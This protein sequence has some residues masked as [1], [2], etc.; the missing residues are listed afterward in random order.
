[1][2]IITATVLCRN[3]IESSEEYPQQREIMK[4]AVAD[5][6]NGIAL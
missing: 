2:E 6:S 5:W 4:P 1:M 3:A